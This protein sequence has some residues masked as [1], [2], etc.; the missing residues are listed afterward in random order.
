M[1]MTEQTQQDQPADTP[2]STPAEADLRAMARDWVVHAGSGK[3]VAM[4]TLR[5][6]YRELSARADLVPGNAVEAMRDSLGKA[7]KGVGESLSKAAETA[8]LT[9]GEASS[10]GKQW[11]S[12]EIRPTLDGAREQGDALVDSLGQALRQ[13]RDFSARELRDG[14]GHASRGASELRSE[15][16]SVS[17][18]LA[19]RAKTDLREGAHETTEQAR[20]LALSLVEVAGGVLEG[21]AQ[22]LKEKK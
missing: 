6:L 22:L 19:R 1:M 21:V 4:D 18:D 15:L 17:G 9:L 13:L 12:E 5:G 8:S 14:A 2:Y 11:W 10:G 16:A 20:A 7:G 3:G